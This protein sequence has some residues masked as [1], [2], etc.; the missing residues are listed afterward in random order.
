MAIS[1]KQAGDWNRDLRIAILLAATLFALTRDG[2]CAS[3][4]DEM[5]VAAS[6]CGTRLC[7]MED[8]VPRVR[9]GKKCEPRVPLR[10]AGQRL[11]R[12]L[13]KQL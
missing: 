13:I 9:V 7:D 8:Q 2:V 3:R 4:L 10:L 12:G 6:V 1:V 5:L 11:G